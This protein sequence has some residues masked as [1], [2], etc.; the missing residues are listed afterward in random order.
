MTDW[1]LQLASP[2]DLSADQW[3][4]WRDLSNRVAGL[5][6]PEFRPDWAHLVRRSGLPAEV[7]IVRRRGEFVAF[8]PFERRRS[9]AGQALAFGMSD[10]HGLIACPRFSIDACELIERCGLSSW[11][12]D[13]LPR[14]QP[15]LTPHRFYQDAEFV[16]DL[17]GDASAYLIDVETRHPEW[18][19]Q[20]ARKRRRLER[21]CGP[22]RFELR[23]DAADAIAALL[24]WKSAK[25]QQS[26]R[27]DCLQWP[28]LRTALPMLAGLVQEGFA[29]WLSALYFGDQLTAVMMSQRSGSHLNAWIPAYSPEHA[30]CSPGALLHL[31]LIRRCSDEGVRRISLGRGENRLKSLLA[32]EAVPMGIGVVDRFAVRRWARLVGSVA[33]Q[34]VAKSPAAAPLRKAWRRLENWVSVA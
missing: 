30:A 25:L 7:A 2:D 5:Q 17:G 8:F 11:R 31:E 12:F 24:R 20:M 6:A 18:R 26:G 19:R 21:E 32:T 23:T 3:S 29:G 34:R 28:W 33:R 14:R 13:H 4:A 1:D 15:C 27:Q 10:C 9:G 16:V 22:M